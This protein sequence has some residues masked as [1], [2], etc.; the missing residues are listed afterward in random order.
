MKMFKRNGV[1]ILG[2]IIAAACICI[3]P[4][5]ARAG[6]PEPSCSGTCMQNGQSG[7]CVFNGSASSPGCNC[8]NGAGAGSDPSCESGGN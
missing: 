5:S 4:M 1:S 2:I 7:N 6:G 8:D 3:G